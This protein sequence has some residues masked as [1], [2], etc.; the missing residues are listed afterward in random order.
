MKTSFKEGKEHPKAQSII[1][2]G[3][4]YGSLRLAAKAFGVSRDKIKR[5]YLN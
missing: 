3:V 4:E 5:M 1:I 2:N